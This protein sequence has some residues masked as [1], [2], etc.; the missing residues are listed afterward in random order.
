MATFF[1]GGDVFTRGC[2]NSLGQLCTHKPHDRVYGV[3]MCGDTI[4]RWMATTRS[5][6]LAGEG[7]EADKM[8]CAFRPIM[9]DWVGLD[10]PHGPHACPPAARVHGSAGKGIAVEA[11]PVMKGPGI[12]GVPVLVRAYLSG[13]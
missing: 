3:Y 13:C 11:A 1:D 6:S 12:P 10:A 4:Q 5:L 9:H 7:W 8:Y 2:K